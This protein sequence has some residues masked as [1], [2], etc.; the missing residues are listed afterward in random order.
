MALSTCR[1]IDRRAPEQRLPCPSEETKLGRNGL[2]L[3]SPSSNGLGAA[4]EEW[5]LRGSGRGW[6]A[7]STASLSAGWLLKRNGN[8]APTPTPPLSQPLLAKTL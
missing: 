2:P 4:E 7:D 1:A 8:A 3:V 5:I 6:S